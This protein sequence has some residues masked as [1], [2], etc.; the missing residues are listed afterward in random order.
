M[1]HDRTLTWIPYADQFVSKSD[2]KE[3]QGY[4]LNFDISAIIL[5][6]MSFK[7]SHKMK[8]NYVENLS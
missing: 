8:K 7:S 3:N 6:A 1:T 5:H 2:G 4:Y